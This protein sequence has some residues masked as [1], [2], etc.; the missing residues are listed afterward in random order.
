MSMRFAHWLIKQREARGWSR[1][2][3]ARY[4]RCHMTVVWRWETGESYPLLPR[5]AALMLLL[6]ADANAV[7]R[8]IPRDEDDDG[9]SAS[10]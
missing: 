10:T 4:M 5:F 2:D 7:L 8:L 3:L 9:P 1:D 6:A